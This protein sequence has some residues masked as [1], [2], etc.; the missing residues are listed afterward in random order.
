MEIKPDIT[1]ITSSMW[2]DGA[3]YIQE[4][5][6]LSFKYNLIPLFL[7]SAF[8]FLLGFSILIYCFIN[9]PEYIELIT[10]ATI[11]EIIVLLIP[12]CL[13]FLFC[14][15]CFYISFSWSQILDSDRTVFKKNLQK[16]YIDRG[17]HT[18]SSNRVIKFKDISQ[19]QIIK[20]VLKKSG[21]SR[22]HNEL[23]LV[24]INN[25]RINLLTSYEPVVNNASRVSRFID[26]PIKII[27]Y[28]DITHL[29]LMTIIKSSSKN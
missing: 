14:F 9:A 15:V 2:S 19:L 3:N 25:E 12:A 22:H 21:K 8:T 23:N 29:E 13:I 5:N 7:R 27:D 6:K 11:I 4:G 28:G 18:G 10:R 1:P 20:Y 26:K 17:K 24:L 16:L